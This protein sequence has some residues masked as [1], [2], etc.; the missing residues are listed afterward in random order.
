MLPNSILPAF[1][2]FNWIEPELKVDWEVE[3]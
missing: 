2:L 3:S 1:R